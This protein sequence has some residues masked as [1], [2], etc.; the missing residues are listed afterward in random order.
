MIVDG[1]AAGSIKSEVLKERR[2]IGE[3]GVM[4]VAIAVDEKGHLAAPVAIETVGVFI[5]DDSG[6]IL[7]EIYAV[8]EQT[9][10]E[11]SGKRANPEALRRAIRTR[12]RDVLRKRDSSFAVIL[13]VISV[14]NRDNENVYEKEFF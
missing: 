11:L 4:V 7:K 1:N 6:D 12:V 2:E 9:V 8:S 13:P 3:D 14:K 10:S 5:A